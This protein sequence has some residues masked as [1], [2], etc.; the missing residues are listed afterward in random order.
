VCFSCKS[1]S[2]LPA[3]GS[4]FHRETS[5]TLLEFLYSFDTVIIISHRLAAMKHC[6]AIHLLENGVTAMRG[7][8]DYLFNQSDALRAVARVLAT[9]TGAWGRGALGKL[10]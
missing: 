9:R 4:F 10:G 2:K 5:V 8:F 6:Y 1:I 3:S 7:K